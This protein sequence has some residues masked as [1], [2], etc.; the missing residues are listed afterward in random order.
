ML[1]VVL[2]NSKGILSLLVGV[3]FQ[4]MNLIVKLLFFWACECCLMLMILFIVEDAY[5]DV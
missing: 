2:L 3:E 5:S 1:A 4:L